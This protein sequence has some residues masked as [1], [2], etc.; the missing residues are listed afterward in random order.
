VRLWR[1]DSAQGHPDA[2]FYLGEMFASGQGVAQNDAEAVRLFRLAAAQGEARA[3][4]NLGV[5][6]A[7][8]QGVAQDFA[9]A[10][11][12]Y[13]L[14]AA[15]G[16]ADAQ[17]WFRVRETALHVAAHCRRG[18]QAWRAAPVGTARAGPLG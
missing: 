11:R 16:S 6:S 7:N 12:L 3:Q 5:M 9:E 1:P 14:A 18:V 10:V 2:Q 15:Q 13:R 4:Y 17:F 8:G